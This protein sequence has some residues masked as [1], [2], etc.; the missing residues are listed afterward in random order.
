MLMR[1]RSGALSLFGRFAIGNPSAGLTGRIKRAPPPLK[2]RGA[3]ISG[4]RE[5]SSLG[6]YLAKLTISAAVTNVTCGLFIFWT[7]THHSPFWG[8]AVLSTVAGVSTASKK[9]RYR[10]RANWS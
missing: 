8:G 10:A 5:G 1:E 7:W 9:F 6:G 4:L 3:D 2:E